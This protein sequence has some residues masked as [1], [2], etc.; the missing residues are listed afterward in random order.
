MP[1]EGGETLDWGDSPEPD[2][3]AEP[4]P[5][6]SRT[7]ERPAMPG[8]TRTSSGIPMSTEGPAP[9][10]RPSVPQDRPS[11][12]MTNTRIALP[13]EPRE[14]ALFK[15]A[16][17]MDNGP[18]V[19]AA[20]TLV[21]PEELPEE[22]EPAPM[23]RPERGEK[24][25]REAR[26]PKGKTKAPEVPPE[27]DGFRTPPPPTGMRP[28]LGNE[29]VRGPV[30]PVEDLVPDGLEKLPDREGVAKR[31]ATDSALLRHQLRPSELPA[32]DR[33]LRLWAFF[34]A[35]A[36]AAA[37]HE[38]TPEGAEIFDK[39]LKEQG[40]AELRDAHTGK[41]G[42][43]RAKWVLNAPHP[44]EARQRAE[45]VH[46]QPE[47]PP[48]VLL[49]ETAQ[50]QLAQPPPEAQQARRQEEP[51]QPRPQAPEMKDSAF[52]PQSPER[53]PLERVDGHAELMRVSPQTAEAP[54][55]LMQPVNPQE[56]RGF[57]QLAPELQRLGGNLKKLGGNMLWNTLHLF[58]NSPEESAVEKERYSQMAFGA[59]LAFVGLMLL[60]ILLVS[61]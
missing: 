56:K 1:Q 16:I 3:G 9:G 29:P 19:D 60:G 23:E 58:R 50:Q 10:G 59:I 34:T 53:S 2:Q 48:E 30:L 54:R 45:R 55:P 37:A 28:A 5:S 21:M 39:A 38:K 41:D 22:L 49:S 52:A 18:L 36:E 8:R 40:F 32:S 26:T 42:L 17:T 33:A 12:G 35:Y 47:L 46:V 27:R 15:D 25:P 51:Q 11:R 44:E 31:F 14:P 4:G 6:R 61:L 7:A 20:R 13:P 43:K 57:D 24:M